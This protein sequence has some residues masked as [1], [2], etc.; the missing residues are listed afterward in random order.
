MKVCCNLWVWIMK[1]I[2]RALALI[3]INTAINTTADA[4]ELALGR[5]VSLALSNDHWLTSSH[6]RETAYRDEAVSHKALPDPTLT[7]G[8]ANL[9]TDSWDFDQENMTQIKIGVTQR[10]PGGNS[11]AVKARKS[12]LMADL[13]PIQ[14][15]ERKAW[16]TRTV[17]HLWLDS[18]LAFKSIQLIENDRGLFEQLVDVTTARYKSAVGHARQQDV[19][20]AQLELTKLEDRLT[21][22]H[23][24]YDI[25]RQLLSEWLPVDTH[26]TPLSIQLPDIATVPDLT[27]TNVKA[28]IKRHPQLMAMDKQ[29]DIQ[30]AD[31]DLAKQAYKPGWALNTAYGYREDSPTGIDRSDFFSIGVTIDLPLFTE[32]RQDRK[33]SAARSRQQA[34]SLDYQRLERKLRA[35]AYKTLAEIARLEERS[36]LYE[37]KLLQQMHEQAEAS[38]SAYTNDDGGFADVMR[39]YIAE[40]NSKIESLEISIQYR[41]SLVTMNYLMAGKA[42][43]TGKENSNE[44]RQ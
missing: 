10:F 7:L 19:V 16:L 25:N 11:R 32:N 2:V 17:S 40:L 5:A 38:L 14:R 8:M 9:P 36:S 35:S 28:L 41:K 27:A 39:A 18:Y 12:Q 21:R 15:T 24:H 34:V 30:H 44:I 1:N 20:R 29:I 6:L 23:M 43:M 13:N 33:V 3:A 26:T 22:L 4:S 31:L 37:N 42:L